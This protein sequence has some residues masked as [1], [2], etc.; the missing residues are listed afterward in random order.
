VTLALTHSESRT[1]ED[2]RFPEL[3]VGIPASQCAALGIEP[4]PGPRLSW[5]RIRDFP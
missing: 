3:R 4:Q 2:G 1:D 5:V